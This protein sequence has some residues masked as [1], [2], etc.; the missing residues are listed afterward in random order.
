MDQFPGVPMRRVLI[1]A[2]LAVPALLQAGGWPQ[3]PQEVWAI[4]EDPAKGIKGAVVLEDRMT[5][6]NVMVEYVYRVRILNEGGKSAA[7][8]EDFSDKAYDI[9]G[10]TVYPDGKEV[11][12]NQRKDFQTK[13]AVKS[14][15]FEIKHTILLPPGLSAD[16][17]V[18]IRWKESAS[19]KPKRR[20]ID[21]I[22][23]R[24]GMSH[25]WRLAHP[26][27]TKELVVELPVSFP[28][29]YQVFPSRS[30]RPEMSEEGGY[31]R[32]TLKDLPAV[33]DLP[34][35]LPSTRDVVRFVVYFQPFELRPF[36]IKGP[37]VYW[38]Q[39]SE[40]LFRNVFTSWVKKGS[41]Y[42]ALKQELSSGLPADPQD[43]ARVLLQHLQSRIRNSSWPTFEEVGR[44]SQEE[45]EEGVHTEDLEA[46][47]SSGVTNSNGMVVL[48]FNLLKDRGL[49]PKIALAAD[50]DLRLF[51][52][53]CL[54]FFQFNREMMVVEEPGRAAL[55]LDPTLRFS[56]PGL[57]LPS[58]QGTAG[59][60]L[61]PKDWSVSRKLVPVQP[62]DSNASEY[63]FNLELGEEA[64]A[65]RM[66]ASFKGYPE[67]RERTR[68]MHLE[69]KE[70]NRQLKED[71]ER[72]LKNAAFSKVEVQHA[73]ESK[74]HLLL[75]AEGRIE[76]EAQR[77]REIYPFPGMAMPL[78]IPDRWPEGRTEF[79]VIPFL[80]TF[81]STS[82][83][84]LP[85]GSS[86]GGISPM[87]NAN[88][89][90]KV[91]WSVSHKQGEEDVKVEMRIEVTTLLEAPSSYDDLRTFLG[92]VQE[93]CG[94]TL[95]IEKS[96]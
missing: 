53:E 1:A 5:F 76:Q 88:R 14:G 90:G 19:S 66:A 56:E 18:E 21:P 87:D 9:E 71:L 15:G 86:I 60:V 92:W 57:V 41:K 30:F 45:Y 7:E 44:Q 39:A 28:W 84:K 17:V 51:R 11:V 89:F 36:A 24:L 61:D 13:T 59:L 49:E 22:P 81:V 73:Q 78:S 37:E 85:E 48:Y 40:S 43:Q 8:F 77:R 58:F 72:N 95:Y 52:M 33:E 65:F 93:A 29:A 25:E 55:W 4:K 67:F 96:R 16:C 47:A 75:T 70:Q 79:I 6:R 2:L 10:R 50:R 31:R 27:F 54:D 23:E 34:Y 42:E 46:I 32:F 83:F 12:F 3:I 63:T 26:F 80:Q 20:W 64:L 82:R 62:N 69:P 38:K 35:S 94:R 74:A 91:Q 68:F